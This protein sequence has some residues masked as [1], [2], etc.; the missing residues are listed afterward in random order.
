MRIDIGID[1]R[2]DMPVNQGHVTRKVGEINDLSA[3]VMC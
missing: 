1:M 3:S 2:I